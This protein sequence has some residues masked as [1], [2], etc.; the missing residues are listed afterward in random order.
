MSLVTIVLLAAAGCATGDPEPA[1]PADGARIVRVVDGDTLIVRDDRG[2]STIRLLGIDTPE[3][4]KPDS[5]VECFG[6]EASERA[7]ELLQVGA[8]V[9][10]ETD[11]S[12][13]RVD[14]FG[15]TLAYVFVKLDT[16]SVNEH[17]VEEGFARVF[18]SRG[19]PFRLESRFTALEATARDAER[20]IWGAC[21]PAGAVSP[22]VE[23]NGR[24]CPASHPIKGNLPSRVYHQPGDPD[25]ENTNPERCFGNAASA[26]AEGFRPVRR[27]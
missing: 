3:S 27:R 9:R 14:E 19:D 7:K 17:L 21:R 24:S 13:D 5:P 23:P 22:W 16:R 26:E 20:G 8:A 1:A 10:V 12:Q 18:I 11:P 2:E 4:V 25:F 6:P 15:R